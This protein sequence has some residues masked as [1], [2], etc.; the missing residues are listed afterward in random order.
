[1]SSAGTEGGAGSMNVLRWAL[2]D[3]YADYARLLDDGPL[4]DWPLLF[5]EE[6]LYLT[7]PRE[8]HDA[9]LPLAT[10]RCESRAML[11][12]RVRAVQETMMYEP[13]FLRHHITQIRPLRR[14]DGSM[15]VTAHYSVVEVLQDELPRILSVGR[16]LDVVIEAPD[17]ALRFAEK[18][19]VY[20]SVMV[21]N[22]LVYPL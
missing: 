20:D 17:G 10:L 5:L 16:Y 22:T 1:M 14:T 19:V 21:P 13:R 6:C 2:E 3:L 15:A 4:E 9:G 12:D 7:I 11:Q 8:N 18:R